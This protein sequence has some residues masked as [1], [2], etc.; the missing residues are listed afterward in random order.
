MAHLS[1][2]LHYQILLEQEANNL[3]SQIHC[4]IHTWI[5]KNRKFLDD[6]AIK[7]IYDRTS[8]NSKDP[9][10]YLYLLYKVH[11]NPVKTCPVISDCGSI[12]YALGKWVDIM[13]HSIAQGMQTYL[14]YS[15]ELKQILDNTT[16]T[17]GA[18]GFTCNAESMYTN[19]D[20]EN[21]LHIIAKLLHNPETQRKY[22]HYH[23][24]TL[25]EAL[26]IVMRNNTFKCGDIIAQQLS[27]M[28]MG[29]PCAPPWATIFKGWHKN[30]TIKKYRPNLQIYL[31]YLDDIFAIWTPTLT[32]STEMKRPGKNSRQQQ[33]TTV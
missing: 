13:L 25:I 6:D 1:N 20:T 30:K 28:A 15:L 18:W 4:K 3:I 8:K 21:A 11:K 2:P 7:Y 19:I 5:S 10:G 29:K 24:N 14:K 31:R 12:T 33:T 23:A 32:I 9:H 22:P 17:P 27:G 26:E 16:V